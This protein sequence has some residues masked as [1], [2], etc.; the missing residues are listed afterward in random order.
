MAQ[1]EGAAS[2]ADKAMLDVVAQK[3]AMIAGRNYAKDIEGA[4]QREEQVG[5]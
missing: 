4:D 1:K 3:I 5:S 2:G